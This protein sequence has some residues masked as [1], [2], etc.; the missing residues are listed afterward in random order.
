M[1]TLRWKKVYV[2][3][4][5]IP[6]ISEEEQHPFVEQVDRILSATDAGP[7]T[8]VR[9]GESEIDRLVF[10]LYGLTTDEIRATTST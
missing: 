5:P 3:A 9:E 8:A 7:N 2:E 10:E 6:R 1:G 4:I